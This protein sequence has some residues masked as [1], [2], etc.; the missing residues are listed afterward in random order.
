MRYWLISLLLSLALLVSIIP[1]PTPDSV[2]L[3]STCQKSGELLPE[4]AKTDT[5]TF[6]YIVS[7]LEIMPGSTSPAQGFYS[8]ATGSDKLDAQVF[9]LPLTED[10]LFKRYSENYLPL[11]TTFLD[12]PVNEAGLLWRGHGFVQKRVFTNNLLYLSGWSLS[13]SLQIQTIVAGFSL[14]VSNYMYTSAF[15]LPIPLFTQ[16]D[17]SNVFEISY[18]NPVALIGKECQLITGSAFTCS[19]CEI[20]NSDLR[21]N[22]AY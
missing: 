8:V 3:N 16:I 15:L 1:S 14:S 13:F 12:N 7:G 17:L 20:T 2:S 22:Y 21:L 6:F 10:P 19:P 9:D 11:L 18:P 5:T 4:I